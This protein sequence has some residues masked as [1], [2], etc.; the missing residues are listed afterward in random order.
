[1]FSFP[2]PLLIVLSILF[3]N[4]D[5][6]EEQKADLIAESIIPSFFLCLPTVLVVLSPTNQEVFDVSKRTLISWK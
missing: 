4:V 5:G 3:Y 6:T 1:M 2:L